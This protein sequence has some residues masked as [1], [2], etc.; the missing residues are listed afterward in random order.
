MRIL[1]IFLKAWKCDHLNYYFIKTNLE[2]SH[3]SYYHTKC[4]RVKMKEI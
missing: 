1:K 2:I 4:N 3:V